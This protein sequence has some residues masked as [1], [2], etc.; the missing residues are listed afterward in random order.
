[1][2]EKLDLLESRLRVTMI[3]IVSALD[4]II[5]RLD[6]VVEGLDNLDGRLQNIEAQLQASD[7]CRD[8]TQTGD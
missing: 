8:A 7:D 1:M 6:G 2:E 5:A 3:V 4:H